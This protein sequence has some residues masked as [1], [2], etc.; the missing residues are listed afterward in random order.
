M[1]IQII[2]KQCGGTE[3]L[4]QPH[5]LHL[6]AQNAAGVDEL[7]FQLPDAWAGCSL[8]LYLRRSDGTLLAPVALDTQHRV[9][10]D[11][12][13]T[14][15]TGG[16]WMLAAMGENGYTAYTRPG[17]YDCYAILPTDGGAEELP[18]SLYEQFVARVLENSSSASTAAQRAAASAASTA[19]NAAQAQ[20]AAQRTSA[21]SANASQCAARA[22]AAAARAEELVP[23]DGQVVSVNG[24]SGIVKLTAQEVGA[25]PCPA[26]PV[27]GQLLRVLSVDPNTGAVLTDTAA[28]PDMSPYLRSSTVPTASVPG[29]VR[30][31]PACGINVR[32]DGTLTTAP[33]DRSQLDSMDSTVLPL[34]PALLPYGVKKALTAAASAGEWTADEKAAALRTL[35]ADLSSYYTKEDIDTLLSA[36]SSGA[37][38]VGSI[39]QST[40]PTS[41]A[42]LFGGS[43]E[44]IASERVLMG[45]SST[46][47]A[48]TTVE[49]GLPNIKGQIGDGK[50]QYSGVQCGGLQ[51]GTYITG[52]YR[53]TYLGEASWQGAGDGI[54][55]IKFDASR[56]SAIYGASTTV[57]PAAY[58]V[59]IWHR[60]A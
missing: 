59:H 13:L 55:S 18:P 53:G 5:R 38:P 3:F 8:A 31:D 42:A 14:G 54:Y 50:T 46:H 6:G 16:Q 48:G 35:G 27:S 43:W 28:M 49:A 44:E 15:S 23:T 36:P 47:A 4:A 1:K 52:A 30:V 33:A 17:S 20:T 21:D 60:V 51:K 25:L 45:A 24:K 12:R 22:E 19:A 10:V 9:T 56:S 57:Q 26:Q 41:P 2:Q 7:L 39:Y 58:Y 40:D 37:Y 11:R 29:A 34:T 32:S